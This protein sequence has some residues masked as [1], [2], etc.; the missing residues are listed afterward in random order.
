MRRATLDL[1]ALRSFV[2]G[3]ELGNFAR[4]ADHVGRSTSAV[5]AHLKKLEELVGAPIL[6]KEGRGLTLTP[7]GEMLLSYARRLLALNDE[8]IV[9]LQGTELSGA[10][11]IGLHEDFGESLLPHMLGEFVR[12]HPRVTV[13]A[14]VVRNLDLLK[15]IESGCLD[16]ALAWDTGNVQSSGELLG[17]LPLCWVASPDTPGSAPPDSRLPL[18]VFEAPCLMRS[19]AIQAL[20][21]AGM[22]WRV[23]LASMSLS[24]IWAA[25][26]AGLG[27]TV[28]TRAGLP[29]NLRV[30]GDLP[31]LPD[32][33]LMLYRPSAMES[34]TVDRLA[35]IVRETVKRLVFG[36]LSIQA[37]ELS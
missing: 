15:M 12:A 32:V 35:D 29:G 2:M 21:Q 3:V 37:T 25:V 27:V 7:A 9:A 23:A 8:A 33:G 17:R 13:E 30:R 5:S 14:H 10:V 28:R 11:R 22:P 36:S 34:A 6:R 19:V 24:G 16:L 4:A 1:D 20:D 26:S 18:V 31:E